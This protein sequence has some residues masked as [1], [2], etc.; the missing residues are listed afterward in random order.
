[1][2]RD[3]SSCAVPASRIAEPHPSDPRMPHQPRFKHT[4]PVNISEVFTFLWMPFRAHCRLA[5]RPFA[6]KFLKR[7]TWN[8]TGFTKF[9]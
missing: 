3:V 6:S 7:E 1:M 9:A 2:K 5:M 8:R 4:Q